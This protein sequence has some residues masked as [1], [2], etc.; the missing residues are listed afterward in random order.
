MLIYMEIYIRSYPSV[1]KLYARKTI[2]SVLFTTSF[3]NIYNHQFT[4]NLIFANLDSTEVD[5]VSMF[6]DGLHGDL[7]S[8]DGIFGGYIPPLQSES[9]FSLSVSTIDY[10]T[11]KYFK[12]P[13]Q[14]R[15]TTAGPVVI[16]SISI[17][18]QFTNYAVTTICSQCWKYFDNSECKLKIDL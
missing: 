13:V 3:S 1:G 6:D 14:G 8:N 15:F 2:D 18:K 4:P 7:L 17:K 12:T 10:Q 9:F 11:N 5:S 16:D